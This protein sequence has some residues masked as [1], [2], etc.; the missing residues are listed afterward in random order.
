MALDVDQLRR[1][2]ED[3][4]STLERQ[5]KDL[6]S[7]YQELQRNFNALF[8]VYGGNAAEEFRQRWART[9][10]WFEEYL[11]KSAALDQFL[12]ERIE[13]LRKL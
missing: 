5:R 6:Q 4:R 13:Q 1:G 2:L 3:Y 8:N 12:T 10:N 9:A 7:K 11:N